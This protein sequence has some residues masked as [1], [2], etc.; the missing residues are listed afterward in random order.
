[1]RCKRNR[2][3]VPKKFEVNAFKSKGSE[4]VELQPTVWI[5]NSALPIIHEV[6]NHQQTM[7][8]KCA[9]RTFVVGIAVHFW[10]LN[11]SW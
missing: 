6:E 11:A 4:G 7:A 1:M 2:E 5:N 10:R 9:A 8:A 3:T